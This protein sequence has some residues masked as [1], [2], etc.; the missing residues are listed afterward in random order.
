MLTSYK[1]QAITSHL[2]PHSVLDNTF[3]GAKRRQKSG[4]S[5]VWCSS[6]DAAFR[7]GLGDRGVM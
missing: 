6:K 7:C 4:P 1:V 3:L 2:L 5:S